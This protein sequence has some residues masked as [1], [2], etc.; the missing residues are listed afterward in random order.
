LSPGAARF[1]GPVMRDFRGRQ[2][3]T[4]AKRVTGFYGRIS[5]TTDKPGYY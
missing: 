1:R 5:G 2:A 4:W 3:I